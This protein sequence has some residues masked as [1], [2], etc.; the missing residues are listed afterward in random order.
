MSGIIKQ[1]EV[2]NFITAGKATFTIKNI[3]TENRYTYKVRAPRDK[4]KEEATLLWVSVMTGPDNEMSYSYIGCLRKLPSGQWVFGYSSKSKLSSQ[5]PSV[6]GFEIIFNTIWSVGKVN[7]NL[8]F[9][10]EGTCCRCGHPLTVPESIASGI[11]PECAKRR[12][13]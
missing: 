7:A 6:K 5:A 2:L 11:G 4:K 12:T 9:W 8:E 13:R 3:A 10:H 1:T